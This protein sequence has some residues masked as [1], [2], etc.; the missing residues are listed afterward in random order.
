MYAFWGWVSTIMAE[1]SSRLTNLGWVSTEMGDPP[2]GS[3][4]FFGKGLVGEF[5]GKRVGVRVV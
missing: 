1:G 4:R 2:W 5:F 3:G